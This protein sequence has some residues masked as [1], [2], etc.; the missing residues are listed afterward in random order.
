MYMK[1]QNRQ[2]LIYSEKIREQWLPLLGRGVVKIWG[3]TMMFS[4]LIEL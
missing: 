2:K 3:M 1:F 4:I